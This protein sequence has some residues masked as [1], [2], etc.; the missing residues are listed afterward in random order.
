MK[1]VILVPR[2]K[3][4]GRRDQLWGFC[5][6]WWEYHAPDLPIFEGH[7]D[8]G[9]FSRAEA[10]NDAARDAGDWS[11]AL[12]IDSD[13]ILG[14]IAQARKALS[15]A[16]ETGRMTY[17][18]NWRYALN[19]ESTD[20]LMAGKLKLPEKPEEWQTEPPWGS[21]GPTFSNC[22]AIRRDLWDEIGGMDERVYGWGVDDW[23]FRVA[24]QT[25]RGGNERVAGNV[26]HLYH[27]RNPETEEGNPMHDT[28]VQLGKRYL[29][30]DGN[31]EGMRALI[32]EWTTLRD[33]G[34]KAQ[35]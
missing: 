1:T 24:P 12:I 25:L 18:H 5:R 31:P 32:A 13:I 10:L 19:A 3:D 17:A 16:Q 8:T 29:H 6:D 28:N 33:S 20:A 30:M 35:R 15:V 14:T 23:I 11:L 26:Y 22:Q 27:P 21:F 9:L 2:R 4:G 34:W 7:H